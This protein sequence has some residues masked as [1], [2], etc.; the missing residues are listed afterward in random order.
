MAS[1]SV[2]F[3]KKPVLDQIINSINNFHN[4]LDKLNL[5]SAPKRFIKY[6]AEDDRPQTKLDRDFKNGMGITCGRF[7]QDPLSHWKFVAL[8][9][10]TIRGA[11]GG[12]ILTAELLYKKGYL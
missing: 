3:E 7:R 8:S 4:P 2:K 5:P 11:A 1:V 6:F 12:A 9:H 10:N